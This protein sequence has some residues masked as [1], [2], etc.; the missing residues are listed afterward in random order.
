MAPS[1]PK[2]APNGISFPCV[3]SC[4]RCC[5]QFGPFWRPLDVLSRPWDGVS[6]QFGPLA[7][8]VFRVRGLGVKRF[9]G[10]TQK[11]LPVQALGACVFATRG[12]LFSVLGQISFSLLLCAST[13]LCFQA[14][15][16]VGVDAAF[17]ASRFSVVVESR[18]G[19]CCLFGLLSICHVAAAARYISPC[20]ASSPHFLCAGG[21]LVDF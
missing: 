12:Q 14:C 16:P 8:L 19:A 9:L 11:A 7:S 21:V 15:F 4:G 13:L 10:L 2:T 18:W 5:G 20:F 3:P 6:D 1:G 17:S